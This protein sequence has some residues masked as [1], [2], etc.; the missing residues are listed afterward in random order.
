M[1]KSFYK[2]KLHSVKAE[3]STTPHFPTMHRVPHLLW[4][5]PPSAVVVEV[6]CHVWL[7]CHSMD[8]SPP[9]SPL[10]MGFPGKNTGVGCHFLL[11]GM[12]LTQGSNSGVLHW[13]VDSLLQNLQGSP[14]N[15]STFWF[16][17]SIFICKIMYIFLLLLSS[18]TKAVRFIQL[19]TSWFSH[20]TMY[21]R[22]HFIT[23][24]R[25]LSPPFYIYLIL[26]CV[27]F[28]NFMHAYFCARY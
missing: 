17:L 2:S 4:G 16:I 8:Y 25:H 9:G 12:L 28:I 7:F 1:S 6:L 15:L 26:L 21:P 14:A 11:Q 20:V 13:L 18:Y 19:L 23:V 24:H 10:S 5:W 3:I 22:D 27:D